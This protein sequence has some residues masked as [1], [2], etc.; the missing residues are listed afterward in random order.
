APRELIRRL[1]Q[2]GYA[3]LKEDEKNQL[4]RV[5]FHV[6]EHRDYW[7]DRLAKLHGDIKASPEQKER[8]YQVMTVWDEYMAASAARFQKERRLKRM[9]ILAGNG[10]IDRGFGIPAR[11]AKRTGGKT[12]TVHLEVGVDPH[13]A[14]ADAAA[15][16]VV[17][18]K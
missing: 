10:H 2:V 13:K 11:A 5:D 3:R 8:S 1:S 15:D 16:F 17:V 12:A 6:K 4:G 14:A 9:V 7:F 18:V